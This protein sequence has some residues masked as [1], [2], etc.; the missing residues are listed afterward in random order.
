M[1]WIHSWCVV[2]AI[3][4][5][6]QRSISEG[7]GEKMSNLVIFSR[8]WGPQNRSTD[9]SNETVFRRLLKVRRFHFN[10]IFK[11]KSF[12]IFERI[13]LIVIIVIVTTKCCWR[14]FSKKPILCPVSLLHSSRQQL[15]ID[16]FVFSDWHQNSVDWL[17]SAVHKCK[18]NASV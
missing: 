5:Y 17:V 13:I 3:H 2:D 4:C 6:F 1:K 12:A 7:S 8:I 16:L 11:L 15:F 9:Y 18:I 10:S 14:Q